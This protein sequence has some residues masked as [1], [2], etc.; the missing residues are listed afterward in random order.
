[1]KSDFGGYYPPTADEY[2][3]LWKDATIVLDTNV[4]LNL[5]RLPTSARDEFL[6]VLELLR[7]RLWIPHQV[8]LEFQRRRLT[9]IASERKVTEDALGAA[10]AVVG[11]LRKKVD[12]LQIEKRG[13]GIEIRPILDALQE[14]N[15]NL[16]AAIEVAHKSQ[17]EIASVDPVRDRL[18][19]LLKSRVGQ[20]PKTQAE[21][22]ELVKDGDHRFRERIPPGFADVEKEKNPNEATF[23]FA[24]LKYQRKF[25]DLILWR[26]LLQHAKSESLKCVLLVTADRKEDWWWREQGK[27]IGAH[28]EL[29]SEI[30]R[31]A[32]VELFWMYSSV[33]F[34]EHANKYTAA[35]VS[36]QAVQELQQVVVSE[37]V[38]HHPRVLS[39]RANARFDEKLRTL[40]FHEAGA[41]LM[42]DDGVDMAAAEECVASWLCTQYGE[43]VVRRRSFPDLVVLDGEQVHGFELVHVRRLDRLSNHPAT[44]NGVSRGYMEVKEGRLASFTIVIVTGDAEFLSVSVG[45]RINEINGRL[46]AVLS[47]YPIDSILVGAVFDGTFRVLAWQAGE[48]SAVPRSANE[49]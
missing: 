11:D 33:Q 17:L 6:A 36:T 34:V 39:T 14:A 25:G 8:A 47:L 35:R 31:D 29:V 3:R 48:Q 46:E 44:L 43:S 42:L 45:D 30:Q 22:D 20:G 2:E 16:V 10:Q 12:A 26:Q 13:L 24:H 49:T 40:L 1:M 27:T 15:D 41:H 37:S 7:D 38:A 5:Y 23:I 4:L 18:D 21:L 32:G 28:P 19:A 9:V